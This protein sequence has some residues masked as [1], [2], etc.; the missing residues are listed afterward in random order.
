M[1]CDMLTREKLDN[2]LRWPELR[3][4]VLLLVRSLKF[5]LIHKSGHHLFVLLGV[6]ELRPVIVRGL[7]RV[8]NS[9]FLPSSAST[10]TGPFLLSVTL[11]IPGRS[12]SMRIGARSCSRI[13]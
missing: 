6:R 7:D 11:P 13:I 12:S 4:S 1:T 3:V 8:F 2:F 9:P 10:S 5:G